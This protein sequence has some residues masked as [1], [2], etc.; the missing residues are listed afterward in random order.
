MTTRMNRPYTVMA[1]R[2]TDCFAF[3]RVQRPS[4]VR[5]AS[6]TYIIDNHATRIVVIRD[7]I[8]GTAADWNATGGW[9]SVRDDRLVPVLSADYEYPS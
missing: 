5:S 8:D 4:T 1:Y 2:G 3:R 6:D 9:K 7:G